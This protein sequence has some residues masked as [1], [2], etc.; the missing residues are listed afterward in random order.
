MT[1]K[2]KNIIQKF[3]A[4]RKSNAEACRR[5][6]KRN[7]GYEQSEARR[8]YKRQW[9]QSHKKPVSVAA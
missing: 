4:L 7:P 6:R 1:E 3:E 5:W 9:Q 8:E 2:E